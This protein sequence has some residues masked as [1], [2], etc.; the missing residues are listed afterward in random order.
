MVKILWHIWDLIKRGKH[1]ARHRLYASPLYMNWR[2]WYDKTP[3]GQLSSRTRDYF[4]NLNYR[5]WQTLMYKTTI[6]PWKRQFLV[7]S[8]VIGGFFWQ[9]Q[10]QWLVVTC[11]SKVFVQLFMKHMT[12]PYSFVATMA[13]I[14]IVNSVNIRLSTG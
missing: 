10:E 13:R 6:Y 3:V 14:Q 1:G 9:F 2:S 7:P 4:Y 8:I 5:F 11:M 12:I